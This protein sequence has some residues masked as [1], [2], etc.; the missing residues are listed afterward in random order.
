[1]NRNNNWIT[2]ILIH[3]ALI[4]TAAV[5]FAASF[6]NPVFIH[7]LPF[8]AWFAY[9][10]ILIVINKYGLAACVC[11]GAVY[12]LTAY[13]LFNYWLSSFHPIAGTIVY[14]I[15]LTYLIIVFVLM[16]AACIFFPKR[17]YLVQWIIWLAYEYLRTLGFLGYSYG[18]TGYSQWQMIPLI[19]I[20]SITGVWGVSALVTF[21][22]FW[23]GA[24]FNKDLLPRTITNQHEQ[25]ERIQSSGSW[26]FVSSVINK[27]LNHYHKEKI[28]A[29]IWAAALIT[30]LTFGIITD[31]KIS[32]SIAK[33]SYP[34]VNIALIQ[35]KPIH[36][37]RH[38]LLLH[39]RYSMR[40]EEILQL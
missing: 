24:A 30:A 23:L 33:D 21:P 2:D 1:M 11:W 9:I 13:S 18:I 20:A 27:I 3:L 7:G 8:L 22:S 39:G 17:G 28:P 5:L 25:R 16:K 10:P 38:K 29:I 19:Q 36:G 37:K 40:T 32:G 31:K 4:L 26:S 12:G 14:T 34:T 15:Y 6:P 35:H